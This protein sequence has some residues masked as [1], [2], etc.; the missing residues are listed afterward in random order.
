MQPAANAP[1][2]R[3]RQVAWSEPQ[4]LGG[5]SALDLPPNLRP[6]LNSPQA[7]LAPELR[8][9][10]KPQD[11]FSDPFGDD[12]VQTRKPAPGPPPMIPP[13]NTAPN[14]SGLSTSP[15][16][17]TPGPRTESLVPVPTR[18]GLLQQKSRA[19]QSRAVDPASAPP[20]G[21]TGSDET[22]AFSRL[23]RSAPTRQL[24]LPQEGNNPFEGLAPSEDDPL[25]LPPPRGG[26][27]DDSGDDEDPLANPFDALRDP[28]D[29]D[30]RDRDRLNS[31]EAAADSQETDDGNPYDPSKGSVGLTCETFRQRIAAQTIRDVS[32]DISPPFRP[33][34]IEESEFQELKTEF[35]ADQE[36]RT[37]RD[38]RGQ[39]LATGRLVDLAYEKVVIMTGYGR[40]E[41]PIGNVSEAD[42]AY[43]SENWGLPKQCLLEQVA[44]VPRAWTP[45]T[46]TWKA[47]NL[48]HKP[49]YFEEVNLERY[50]HTAGPVLQPVVSSA[51]FFAN[52]AVLPY[53]MGV[54]AP[55]ECQYALGY[56]RPGN[57]APWIVPPVPI[58]LRGGLNQAATM[59][60]LFW[61]VP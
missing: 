2:Q 54:H 38:I 35:D 41:L 33:D 14:R 3:V 12:S 34:V 43:I 6:A 53:K 22:A 5:G 36:T 52:I 24:E 48:C 4:Q 49:L 15:A 44:Y 20:V 16:I 29:A 26:A 59:T 56:Y 11:F 58:S 18:S 57:C 39:T 19:T 46:M 50:G 31:G 30:D 1:Q 27:D 60:G 8:Q 42:L 40:E 55:G 7:A 10:A 23:L 25:E 51:H 21:K 28:D 37:W 45:L 61:L 13:T 9:A 47:S 32:L 17:P